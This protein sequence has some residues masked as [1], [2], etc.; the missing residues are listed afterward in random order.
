MIT[1]STF[2]TRES[3]KNLLKGNASKKNQLEPICFAT[4]QN[5]ECL[6]VR[7]NNFEGLWYFISVGD[8][9]MSGHL[10]TENTLFYKMSKVN[11]TQRSSNQWKTIYNIISS[12]S[13]YSTVQVVL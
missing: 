1:F 8:W 13:E 6:Q 12:Y 3:T 11:F 2:I 10:Q 9:Q 4:T 5:Y 7:S